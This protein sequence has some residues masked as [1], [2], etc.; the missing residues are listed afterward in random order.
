MKWSK[1]LLI[2]VVVAFLSLFFCQET[3]TAQKLDR[4][5]YSSCGK[6]IATATFSLSYNI[7]E[8][9]VNTGKTSSIILSQG[10]EQPD[11]AVITSVH[12]SSSLLFITAFPNPV[13]DMLYIHQTGNLKITDINMEIV[14]VQGKRTIQENRQYLSP[15]H[16][17]FIDLSGY[18]SGVYLIRLWAQKEEFTTSIKII[19]E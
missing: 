4:T 8:T 13:K 6:H 10:F 19:K 16:P 17:I 12:S 14:D 15:D 3:L 7:G 9:I 1:Q 11:G 5:I 2:Y 18:R